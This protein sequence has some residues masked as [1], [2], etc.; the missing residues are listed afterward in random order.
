MEMEQHSDNNSHRNNSGYWHRFFSWWKKKERQLV[1]LL[2]GAV[3]LVVLLAGS[4]KEWNPSE[5]VKDSFKTWQIQLQFNPQ[6]DTVSLQ[7]MSILSSSVV[8]EESS[9]SPYEVVVIDPSQNELLIKRILINEIQNSISLPQTTIN[10][11]YIE[12]AEKLIL[13]R[14]TIPIM[15]I[16]FQ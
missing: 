14:N 15:E 8:T 10:I 7:K 9:I 11:P 1:P 6:N 4:A 5:G 2:L 13:K 16:T 12:N 3:V